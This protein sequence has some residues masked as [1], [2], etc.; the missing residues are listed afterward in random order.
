LNPKS[1]IE[2]ARMRQAVGAETLWKNRSHTRGVPV[3]FF[4]TVYAQPMDADRPFL[5]RISG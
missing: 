2:M 3:I 4:Q 5:S 1:E